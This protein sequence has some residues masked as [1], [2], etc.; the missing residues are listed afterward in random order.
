L[1]G[2]ALIVRIAEEHLEGFREALDSVA[3]ER[4]YLAL[5]EAPPLAEMRKF[6][7]RTIAQRAP[8]FVA[9]ADARVVGWC[10]IL[11]KPH[12]T[13]LHSGVLGMGVISEYRG[14]GIGRALMD[15]TLQA[16]KARGI[17][18]VELT[19]RVDNEPAKRLYESFGFEVEG[20]CR[21]HMRV[22]GEYKDS[23]LMALVYG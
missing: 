23:Y 7:L 12:P 15:A 18:R 10:D 22:A 20:K 9:L 19:V 13:M 1:S 3:R 17:S 8:Q 6:V 2:V 4:A 5:L 14:R 16:A 11:P 21:R